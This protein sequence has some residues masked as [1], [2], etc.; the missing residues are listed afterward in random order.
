MSSDNWVRI[1]VVAGFVD[2]LCGANIAGNIISAEKR[3]NYP[4]RSRVTRLVYHKFRNNKLPYYIQNWPLFQNSNI[5]NHNTRG[6][7]ALH[8]NRCLHVFAQK[9]LKLNITNIVNDT[10]HIILEKIDTHSFR[11][12]N[13]FT[14][15][16]KLFLL[17]TYQDTCTVPNCYICSLSNTINT[18]TNCE[19]K[20]YG[21]FYF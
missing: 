14:N 15:Y 17:Q 21:L 9:S 12:L 16:V 4:G 7:N 11:S 10:P 1:P 2:F 6:A 8:K 5:R 3:C 20:E 13:G 18:Q 19:E